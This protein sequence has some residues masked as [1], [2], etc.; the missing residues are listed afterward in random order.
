MTGGFGMF[1]NMDN[2]A[3]WSPDFPPA[4]QLSQIVEVRE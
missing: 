3:G 1:T 4:H 2:A